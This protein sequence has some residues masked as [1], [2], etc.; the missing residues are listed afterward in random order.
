MSHLNN[1]CHIDPEKESNKC[2][3]PDYVRLYYNKDS[4]VSK[5]N[6]YPA[7]LSMNPGPINPKNSMYPG[8]SLQN[9]AKSSDKLFN[10]S[11]GGLIDN[12]FVQT[13]SNN[14]LNSNLN[15]SNTNIPFDNST[16]NYGHV[17]SSKFY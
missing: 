7:P 13:K 8:D 1:Y 14:V 10:T 16:L 12:K 15:Y 9:W 4:Q 17:V 6:Y 11:K 3:N 5:L 2:N